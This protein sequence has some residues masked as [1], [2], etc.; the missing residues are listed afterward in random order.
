LKYGKKPARPGAVKLKFADYAKVA[1]LPEPPDDFGH[2]RMVNQWGVLFND[3]IGDCAI[4]GALH[5]TLLWNTEAGT[6]IALEDPS[7]PPER[8]PVVLNYSAI[9]G[10]RPGPELVYRDAPENPTDNG[11]DI[12]DLCAYRRTTHDRRLRG[13]GAWQFRATEICHILL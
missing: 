6:R 9:T 11:T 12:A 13:V 4:A 1:T 2:E 8:Q 3:R 10:Y 5:E 7:A